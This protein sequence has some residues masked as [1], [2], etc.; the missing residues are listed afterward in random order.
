MCAS[1]RR[2]V[3]RSGRWRESRRRSPRDFAARRMR[4]SHSMRP[5]SGRCR[6]SVRWPRTE[7]ARRGSLEERQRD[8]GEA[9]A[10]LNIFRQACDAVMHLH[11]LPAPVLHRDI[12]PANFLIAQ[13]LSNV[14]LADFGIA[15]PLSAPPLTEAFEVVGTP[16]Y[17]APE[18]TNGERG[19]IESDVYCMGRLLEWL[20][21]GD[22]A[23]NMATRPV[24][25]GPDL[26]DEACSL[27]DRVV[28]KATQA[29]PA[30]RFASIKEMADQLPELWLSARPRPLAASEHTGRMTRR[31]PRS[32]SASQVRSAVGSTGITRARAR[33]P[34]MRDIV[35]SSN[36]W[37][38]PSTA[39][40]VL[41]SGRANDDCVFA[42]LDG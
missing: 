2:D 13:E 32:R 35:S 8:L 29:V 26:D 30:N 1:R 19:T 10:R 5:L 4:S 37:R 21:T 6:Y 15:R 39:G 7:R 28:A 36:R 31:P 25:R 14:V 40:R 33:R 38:P 34:T 23:R 24:P 12:K 16:F 11:G 20:L 18:V 9:R 41:S 27:L 3:P 17:R 22:V 42:P